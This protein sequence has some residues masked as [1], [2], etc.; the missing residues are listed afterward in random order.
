MELILLFKLEFKNCNL[1]E[2]RFC[3]VSFRRKILK[4]I[5]VLNSSTIRSILKIVTSQIWCP[6]QSSIRMDIS[7]DLNIWDIWKSARLL[8]CISSFPEIFFQNGM[9]RGK[10]FN[11]HAMPWPNYELHTIPSRTISDADP[12]SWRIITIELQ[13]KPEL[14]IWLQTWATTGR[15]I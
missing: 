3:V 5:R 1:L 11:L 2:Q 6:I 4:R 7:R 15:A 10:I 8:N 14:L 13:I 12:S 9:F